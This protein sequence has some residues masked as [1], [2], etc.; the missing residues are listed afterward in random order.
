MPPLLKIER[1]TSYI[2]PLGRVCRWLPRARSDEAASELT[3][4]YLDA[5]SLGETFTLTAQQ[6]QRLLKARPARLG[7]DGLAWA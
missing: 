6:A 5:A 3:F 4:V 1:N 7:T 2:T